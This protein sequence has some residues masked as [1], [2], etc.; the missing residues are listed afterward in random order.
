MD[1]VSLRNPI[2]EVKEVLVDFRLDFQKEREDKK[3]KKPIHYNK[4][5]G[6]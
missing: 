2:I 5:D 3:S 1:S 6:A 4:E